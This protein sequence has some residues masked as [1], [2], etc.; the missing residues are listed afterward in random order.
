MIDR[1]YY[2]IYIIYWMTNFHSLFLRNINENILLY[3][4]INI[5]D[6]NS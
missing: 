2:Q 5:G 6:H 1:E 4:Y 3:I